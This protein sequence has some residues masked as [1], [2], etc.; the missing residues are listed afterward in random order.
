MPLVMAPGF[1]AGVLGAF[2]GAQLLLVV[3]SLL[4]GS[5]YG[6]RG[7]L[8]HAAAIVFGVLAAHLQRSALTWLVPA[9]LLAVMALSALQL[10]DITNHVGS[11]RPSQRWIVGVAGVLGLLALAAA[12]LRQPLV[13]PVGVLV[14]LGLDVFIVPRAWPQ[15][16]PWAQWVVAGQGA[17][18]AAGL[19][20]CVPGVAAQHDLLLPAVLAFWSMALYLALV[21][22]SRVF[23]E[24]RWKQA[25]ERLQ[26]PLTG[27]ATPLVLGQ[28]IQS[29]RSLMRRYGHPSS[30]M[31]VHVDGLSHV[32]ASRGE[33]VAEATALEAGLRIRGSLGPADIAARV[34]AHRFAILTEGSSVQEASGDV[35]SRVLVAGLKEPLHAI[36]GAFLN[37]R[38]VVGGLPTADASTPDLLR[39]LGERLDTDVARGRER[40]IRQLPAEYLQQDETE[41]MPMTTY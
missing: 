12:V 40:R 14:L 37:F 7:L 3:L 16:Q 9:A 26:D 2:T 19:W 25:V 15:S 18:L 20:L 10:R 8:V 39:R 22:R 33:Q 28:R 1:E 31:L 5:A 21:W 4:I 11:L 34:G 29:A 6:E 38:I 32:A 41:P 27:L 13:L 35:A 23:G 17:L 24:R 36:E 30:L